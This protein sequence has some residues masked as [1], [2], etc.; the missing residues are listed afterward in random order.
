[1]DRTSS[2]VRF[3]QEDG[4]FERS[5]ERTRKTI[6]PRVAVSIAEMMRAAVR[7]SGWPPVTAIQLTVVRQMKT[8]PR[9]TAVTSAT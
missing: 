6:N 8:M 1:M 9:S 2:E 5:S 3:S 7:F 4:V